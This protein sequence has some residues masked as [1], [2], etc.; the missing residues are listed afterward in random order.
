MGN[1]NRA[2]LVRAAAALVVLLACLELAAAQS[3]SP[4]GAATS[5]SC[6][7][8]INKKCSTQDQCLAAGK[9][10]GGIIGGEGR[11][12]WVVATAAAATSMLQR[13]RAASR[14]PRARAGLFG[15][16]IGTLGISFCIIGVLLRKKCMT[17]TISSGKGS[18]RTSKTVWCVSRRGC[19][20]TR[21]YGYEDCIEDDYDRGVC[22]CFTDPCYEARAAAARA[23][24]AR[25]AATTISARRIASMQISRPFPA[26]SPM[27]ASYAGDEVGAVVT[28]PRP[29]GAPAPTTGDAP[30]PVVVSVNN[31]MMVHA[32]AAGSGAAKT[33]PSGGRSGGGDED[34]EDP[35][36]VAPGTATKAGPAAAA[37]A[38]T[39][40]SPVEAGV[41]WQEAL[42]TFDVSYSTAELLAAINGM[43]TLVESGVAKAASADPRADVLS[44]GRARM[45]VA[46][47]T[48][49]WTRDVAAAYGGL[50][51][52]MPAQAGP[53]TASGRLWTRS[54]KSV[55][56]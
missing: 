20:V 1:M 19:C 27:P 32:A 46:G 33:D 47:P 23:E 51:Q 4:T 42:A 41:E 38:A 22:D 40:L 37:A 5:D 45:A 53:R 50:L 35:T 14:Y 56:L 16:V 8:R 21:A 28:V 18:S 49:Q 6:Y 29:I 24:A 10:I 13:L 55:A 31:N 9:V 2:A 52:L 30:A 44:R 43:R 34:E 54:S 36:N 26:G 39:N 48:H 25:A 11:A 12:C 7:C 3:A 17:T 15:G